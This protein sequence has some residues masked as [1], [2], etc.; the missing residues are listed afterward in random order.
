MSRNLDQLR[1][2]MQMDILAGIRIR[3]WEDEL[4]KNFASVAYNG[5]RFLMYATNESIADAVYRQDTQF[6]DGIFD[7]CIGITKL[8]GT[9]NYKFLK[10]VEKDD[11]ASVIQ[12]LDAM[13]PEKRQ[14][15]SFFKFYGRDQRTYFLNAAHLARSPQMIAAMGTR[16]VDFNQP[17]SEG[18]LPM[19]FIARHAKSR[20]VIPALCQIFGV[21]ANNGGGIPKHIKLPAI[22]ADD[23]SDEL[24]T[25]ELERAVESLEGLQG[26]IDNHIGEPYTPVWDAP[27]I[28]AI[29]YRNR[30]TLLGLDM[31]PK[32]KVDWNMR[33][34]WNRM[35]PLIYAVL[36]ADD[37]V[38]CHR[39]WHDDAAK[40]GDMADWPKQD[41]SRWDVAN[42]LWM[43]KFLAAH[44]QIDPNLRDS[45][46]TDAKGYAYTDVVQHALLEGLIARKDPEKT[47]EKQP[48]KLFTAYPSRCFT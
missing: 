7:D 15:N 25:P 32:G 39:Q 38:K 3:R 47:Q 9:E 2:F 40:K 43:V 29:K 28:R 42:A 24:V 1:R 45:T 37:I 13:A 21:N 26:K 4:R 27:L 41:Y 17:D 10:D 14:D 19:F 6:M 35:T 31:L 8:K 30:E 22:L 12:K 23:E 33:F 44:P 16:G 34:Q 48:E 18:R 46:A 20:W 11:V 36:R 5:A